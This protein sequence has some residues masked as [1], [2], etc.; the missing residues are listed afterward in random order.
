MGT[1]RI[2]GR[3]W[4]GEAPLWQ[5]FWV[6]GVAGSWILAALFAAAAA[7]LGIT[8][9]LYL[10]TAVLMI[11]YTTWI[12][13]SV[14]RCAV[15]VEQP[16]WTPIARGLTVAWAINVLLVGAFLGLDLIGAGAI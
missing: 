6:W 2:I 13:G 4:H 12:L 16:H 1:T 15:N 11:A 7:G 3:Y 10:A 9:G 14:W 8:L 5:A